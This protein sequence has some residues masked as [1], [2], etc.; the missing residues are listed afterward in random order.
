MSTP[1]TDALVALR[2]AI[3]SMTRVTEAAPPHLSDAATLIRADLLRSR[4]RLEALVKILG[5]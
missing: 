5:G 3:D 2:D 1:G 4:R